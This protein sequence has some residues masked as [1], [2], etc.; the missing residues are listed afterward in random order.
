MKTRLTVVIMLTL[1]SLALFWGLRAGRK[2]S[3]ADALEQVTS[4]SV[5]IKR[6][7]NLI[8]LDES[9]SMLGL[10]E[11]SV[12]GVNQTLHTIRKAYEDFPQ[13]EQCVTFATFSGDPSQD[14]DICRVRRQVQPI[15]MVDDLEWYEYKP[16]GYTPLWDAMGKLLTELDEVVTD[17]D[18][19]LVSIITDGEE[20]TSVKYDSEKIKELVTTLGDKGW[21]FTYIGANQNAALV[22]GQMGIRNSL[23]YTSDIE[24]TRRMYEKESCSRSNYYHKACT[25]T[26]IKRLQEGYFNEENKGK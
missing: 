22:A 21:T 8:I 19:V 2:N 5:A 1:A 24:G 11:V 15:S 26:E 17:E 13:L 6:V 7:Y 10:Q 4:D 3:T 18:L 14:E 16:K 9:G 20:N 23:Q 25:E 12:A